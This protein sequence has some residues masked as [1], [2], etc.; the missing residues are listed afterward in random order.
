M[1]GIAGFLSPG[2]GLEQAQLEDIVRRMTDAIAY[3][4][5]DDSGVFGDASM[6]LALG[7]RRLSIVDLSP[8]GH[9]PM[10]SSCGR[11]VVIFNGEIYNFHELRKDLEEHGAD[12]RGHSDTEVL[13]A[14]VSRWGLAGALKRFVGMFAF[15]LWD[16]QERTLSLARDR[17]G[18]KPLYYGWSGRTFLFGSE[19]KALRCHPRWSGELDREALGLYLRF[20]FIPAPW[21]IYRGIRK[22]LPGSFLTVPIGLSSGE[23]QPEPVSYWDWLETAREARRVGFDGADHEAVDRLDTLLRA[24]ISGQMCADVPVGAFLSGGIDSSTTVAVM[25]SLSSRPVRTF[26]IGFA[27]SK[28][29]EAPYA[30]EIARHLGT[31][32]T[33]LYVQPQDCLG[34]IP[35]LPQIYDEPFADPSQIP[36]ILVCRLAR[37]EVTVSLSGDAGDEL[38]GGYPRYN[39]AE[40]RWRRVGPIPLAARRALSAG[41]RGF[42]RAEPWVRLCRGKLA[43]TTAAFLGR[44][45]GAA[46]VLA[47]SGPGEFYRHHN[48]Q[49]REP[50]RLVAGWAA[51]GFTAFCDDPLADRTTTL[52]EKGMAI[53]SVTYLPDDILVKLDRASMSVSLESR[54]PLLDHRIIEFAWRMPGST[55]VRGSITKWALR[56]VLYRYV[57]KAMVERPKMGFGIPLDSWLRG[58][59]REWAE[60]LLGERRLRDQGLLNPAPVRRRWQDHLSGTWDRQYHLW[61]VLM[62]QA[63]LEEEKKG[64]GSSMA[65]RTLSEQGH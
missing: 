42:A 44:C 43:R 13:L 3:R 5:P 62:L 7:H 26:T 6:G 31:D 53:D 16:R 60:H 17:A 36:T 63:W 10:H 11:F 9:Q 4:G 21:S 14:G 28:Y 37:R 39:L 52:T 59:L 22:L 23:K 30:K 25:Q 24:A 32:H 34:L 49:W 64:G 8:L 65:A 1:C 40:R 45:E 33:E 38:F 57:P 56:E 48:S 50:G 19:L 47:S 51:D 58:P 55:K 20:G 18:E 35:R 15:A 2:T 29:D 12:F 61:T 54:V 46:A 27:E 41:L